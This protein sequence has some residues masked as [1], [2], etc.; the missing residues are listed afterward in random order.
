MA[1]LGIDLYIFVKF[2]DDESMGENTLAYAGSY[3]FDNLSG[4][5]LL[6]IVTINRNVDFK[7]KIL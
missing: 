6:G 2:G 1:D 4:Q 7:K 3:Y 5:P